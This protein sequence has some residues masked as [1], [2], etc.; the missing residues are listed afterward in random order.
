M[1]REKFK[2]EAAEAAFFMQARLAVAISFPVG[3]VS[4]L[5]F[6]GRDLERASHNRDIAGSAAI[7][8]VCNIIFILYTGRPEGRRY[9]V[10]CSQE[11]TPAFFPFSIGQ[12][13][14][15]PHFILKELVDF[16]KNI[17]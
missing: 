11:V 3:A 5:R 15:L 9:V 4:R 2:I 17:V 8:C 14:P 6:S 7:Y 13:L 1:R 16:S 10:R 12:F